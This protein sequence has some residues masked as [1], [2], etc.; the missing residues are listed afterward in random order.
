ML[1]RELRPGERVRFCTPGNP[2][3]N[4]QETTVLCVLFRQGDLVT[5]TLYRLAGVASY[6]GGREVTLSGRYLEYV[7]YVD[8]VDDQVP[9]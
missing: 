6:G 7:E 5:H 3:I 9:L 8:D 4:G 1:K 2:Y